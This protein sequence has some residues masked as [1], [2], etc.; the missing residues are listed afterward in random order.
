MLQQKQRMLLL[1]KRPPKMGAP[2]QVAVRSGPTKVATIN[3]ERTESGVQLL[4]IVPEKGPMPIANDIVG[5]TIKDVASI[6]AAIRRRWS[7]DP[8]KLSKRIS[9]SS[10]FLSNHGL[11]SA[12]LVAA[13]FLDGQCVV[14]IDDG[15]A[16]VEK[17]L[18]PTDWHWVN[19]EDNG[20]RLGA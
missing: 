15:N 9:L 7:K 4:S 6:R 17:T 20:L 16:V 1:L 8:I 12:A 19:P 11:T 14:Q 2:F 10:K 13:K 3:C 5:L 18:A